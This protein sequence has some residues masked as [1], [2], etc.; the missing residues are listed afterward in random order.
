MGTWHASHY[1]YQWVGM[2]ASRVDGSPG[3]RGWGPTG[4]R[5]PLQSLPMYLSREGGTGAEGHKERRKLDRKPGAHLLAAIPRC[6][7]RGFLFQDPS[8]VLST[9]VCSLPGKRRCG[10]HFICTYT[11]PH[12]RH[13]APPP[14][15]AAVL[16]RNPE[17][18]G[19]RQSGIF[20]GPQPHHAPST[21]PRSHRL[22][23]KGR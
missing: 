18:Q 21:L 19:R 13:L 23:S 7:R 11:H 6:C 5:P 14:P 17:S 20:P 2:D 9:S 10:M 8:S 16:D 22:F 4:F 1:G 3:R 15:Y 12:H